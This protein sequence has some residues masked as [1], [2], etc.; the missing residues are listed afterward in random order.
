M[1]ILAPNLPLE[2]TK[3]R[4]EGSTYHKHIFWEIVFFDEGVCRHYYNDE[5]KE[6]SLGDVIILAPEHIHKIEVVQQ[7]HGHR[8]L[9][10]TDEQFRSICNNFNDGL[11]FEALKS[12]IMQKLPSD[13]ASR[14]IQQLSY[15]ETHL[16]RRLIKYDSEYDSAQFNNILPICKSIMA[17]VLGCYFLKNIKPENDIPEWLFNLLSKLNNPLNLSLSPN[18]II[19]ESGFSHSRFSELF[20]FYMKTSLVDYLI[21]KRLD[22][23][24][25]LLKT[26]QKSTMEISLL[27]GYESYSYFFKL[28]KKNYSV[29]PQ[30]YRNKH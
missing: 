17:Y 26:T 5:V 16:N 9:Y 13:I 8:D 10:F 14:L 24:A 29:S 7:P 18:E 20:K 6:C 25:E 30:E 2:I 22:Y 27:L 28:F 21:K 12:P 3:Y 4:I 15:V 23:A 19:K 1:R 11:Y